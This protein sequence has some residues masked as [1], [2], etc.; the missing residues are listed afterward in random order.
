MVK[1]GILGEN[2]YDNSAIIHLL[3][4]KYSSKVQFVRMLE[5]YEGDQLGSQKVKKIINLEF[6]KESPKFILISRDLDSYRTDQ[7]K[8]NKRHQWFN[9]I[10]AL[11]NGKSIFLLNIW[12]LEAL[13]LAD[14]DTFN[15]LY[16]TSHKFKGDP[17]LQKEPKEKLKSLT[18]KS[19][20]RFHESHCPDVFQMLDFDTV[21][22]N[23]TY[24][25]DFI[26]A[27]EKKL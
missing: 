2:P 16:K 27:F 21:K 7:E 5:N 18:F 23:C 14:I 1:I 12:E 20:K 6:I 13:I 17:S 11:T 24:F 8:I 19:Q 10:N 26:A 15:K 4:Q 25:R 3:N 22:S 9:G